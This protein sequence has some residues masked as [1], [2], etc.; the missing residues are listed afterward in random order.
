MLDAYS[1]KP[2]LL[3][4]CEPPYS[5]F[6]LVDELAVRDTAEKN[7][8]AA[9]P[10]HRFFSLMRKMGAKSFLLEVLDQNDELTD[11]CTMIKDALGVTVSINVIRVT[12]FRSL[13]ADRRWQDKLR[14]PDDEILGY[15]VVVRLVRPAKRS[16]S[17]VYEAVVI[18]PT[19]AVAPNG[20]DVHLS[21]VANYYIHNC[22]RFE[23]SIGPEGGNRIIP[24]VGSYFAQQNGV[25]HVCAHAALRMS[26]NSSPLFIKSGKLTNR[27]INDILKL[28]WTDI[29]RGLDHKQMSSVI[30]AL[31][32]TVQLAN[33]YSRPSME[34]DQFVYPLM[35]SGC[36]VILNVHG[37]SFLERSASPRSEEFGH[38]LAVIGHTIN[39]DRWEPEARSGYGSYQKQRDLYLPAVAWTD[40]LIISD[41]NFGMMVTL[42]TDSLRNLLIPDKNPA[43][44][45]AEAIGIVPKGVKLWGYMAE[46]RA[47]E[48]FRG[49]NPR[50]FDTEPYW[51]AKLRS[52]PLVCRTILQRRREYIV[53][54]QEMHTLAGNAGSFSQGLQTELAALP[55]RVWVTELSIPQLY[56]ANRHKVA[57]VLID[58]SADET[59]H[60][61]GGS[62]AAVRL[63]GYIWFAKSKNGY[64]WP[65][66]GHTPLIAQCDEP[67]L[68]DW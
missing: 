17:F 64:A 30:Q 60:T 67:R 28:K 4:S 19:I 32:G 55:R 61:S 21:R 5:F 62:L 20:N 51:M 46:Q 13:P 31:G 38:A 11:E 41:D 68:C 50:L 52:G 1:S 63:P 43:L 53:H 57:D 24:L 9:V 56:T 7:V 12:F 22:R 14:L 40:H 6:Q 49:I 8:S 59:L 42:P 36:P 47:A 65:I 35:E 66:T 18:S 58:A 10:L 34:Y 26:I 45:A 15:A 2:E 33:F 16:C 27:R 48:I 25:T 3:R 44:H 29:L 37:R 23:T 39:T 54:L